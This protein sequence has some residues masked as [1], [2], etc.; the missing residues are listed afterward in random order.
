M[1]L[2]IAHTEDGRAVLDLV[3]EVRPPFG[4]D[5]TV[6]DFAAV[7]RSYGLRNVTGDR[8]AGE[9]PR[10]RFKV[11]GVDYELS[12]RPKSDLYR[13][14]LPMLNSGQAELLD[15]PRLAAQLTGLERRTARSG[16]DSIDHGPGAHDDL[17]NAVAGAA[18][19]GVGRAG[20]A[21]ALRPVGAHGA[22]T[23]H[24]QKGRFEVTTD[25]NAAP[26]I[27]VRDMPAAEYR[28]ARAAVIRQADAARKAAADAEEFRKIEARF[29]K[30]AA[31]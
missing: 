29:S 2:A 16:R 1:T 7:L 19:V 26:A 6:Q 22:M 3:R 25:P 18:T 27:D 5:S 21:G 23:M 13:D 30:G 20:E 4:P 31:R 11:H 14:M 8:Y 12:D 15:L 24:T 9:W 28:A 10:E 17:A